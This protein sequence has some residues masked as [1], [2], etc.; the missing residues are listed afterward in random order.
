MQPRAEGGTGVATWRRVWARLVGWPPVAAGRRVVSHYTDDDGAVLAAMLAFQF[1]LALF[2]IVLAVAGLAG[3]VL[4]SPAVRAEVGRLVATAVPDPAAAAQLRTLLASFRRQAGLLGVLGL[5]GLMWAGSSLFGSVERVLD[6]I[7]R[8]SPRPFW[9]QKLLGL[10]MMLVFA[11]VVVLSVLL[12]WAVGTLGPRA[13]TLGL[14]A[15]GGATAWV[16]SQLTGLGAALGLFGLVYHAVPRR[17]PPWRQVW[18]GSLL[19][20]IG[21]QALSL[22]YPL[23]AVW[24][25]RHSGYGATF[26]LLLLLLSWM[27]LTAQLL[28]LGGELNAV[29]AGPAPVAQGEAGS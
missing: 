7:Q 1:T 28:V 27:Y 9:E 17:H 8:V 24:A 25:Q 29:L 21:L 16:V 26:G 2:P 20:A 22:V 11:A 14:P 4:H 10:T 23:Y 15:L 6:R 12:G 3:L 13:H 19:A 18:P 5:G